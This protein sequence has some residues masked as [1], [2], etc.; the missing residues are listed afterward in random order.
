[1]IKADILVIGSGFGGAVAAAKLVDAGAQVTLI[2]RGTWRDRQATRE[3][4]VLK[5]QLKTQ[6]VKLAPFPHGRHLPS[7][8]IRQVSVGALTKP[9]ILNIDGLFDLNLHQNMSVFC[10]SGVG[11]GSHV[12]W[13]MNMRPSDA[14][15]WDNRADGVDAKSMQPHYDWILNQMGSQTIE[16]QYGKINNQDSS[17][18]T[19]SATSHS[20]KKTFANHP[21]IN[22]NLEQPALGFR[23]D[24]D[25]CNHGM[26]G[27]ASNQ[28][29][30]LDEVFLLPRLEKGLTVH[31]HQECISIARKNG[32]YLIHTFNHQNKTKQ[33]FIANQVIVAAGT[34][35]TGRILFRSKQQG[36]AAMPALGKG[37]SGNGDVFAFWRTGLKQQ[38]FRN[39]PPSMGRFQV[40]SAADAPSI[41]ATGFNILGQIPLLPKS[42]QALLKDW[43][44][45]VAM[46]ED[47]SNGAMTWTKKDIQVSFDQEN[48]SIFKKIYHSFDQLKGISKHRAWFLP[49]FPMTVHPLGGA[50]VGKNEQEGVVSGFG[51]VYG[52]P[53]LFITDGSALPAATGTPP[54]MSI[55]AWSSHV[56][57]HI[58]S[59][60]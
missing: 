33:T 40:G 13:S 10:S 48:S 36:L 20:V 12:Y 41:Y 56:A 24:G 53:N 51:E 47:A 54:S 60:L 35:N 17:L 27:D 32:Q 7:H 38:D 14:Q 19:D 59:K 11:G 49:Q 55:A 6:G 26:L 43:L 39:S 18:V 1:M 2:E 31:T 46:G 28:K 44:I 37:F 23:F 25:N 21:K 34:L 9:K 42:M 50:R 52:C 30:G 8:F 5:S 58:I 22:T 45:L 29:V 3:S 16:Q 57:D 4:T 15:Y